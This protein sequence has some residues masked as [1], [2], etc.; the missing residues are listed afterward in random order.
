MRSGS[1]LESRASFLSHTHDIKQHDD[2]ETNVSEARIIEQQ[3]LISDQVLD[4]LDEPVKL[5]ES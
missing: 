5:F 2:S 3:M 1:N 4:I